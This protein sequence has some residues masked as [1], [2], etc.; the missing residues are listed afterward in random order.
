[1]GLDTSKFDEKAGTA[2]DKAKTLKETLEDIPNPQL[3]MDTTDFD[4]GVSNATASTSTLKETLI[5]ALSAIE[6][7]AKK[8][9]DAVLKIANVGFGYNMDIEQYEA[10]FTTLMGNDREGA[11]GLVRNRRTLWKQSG[12]L[13][14]MRSAR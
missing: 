1:M 11:Q 4:T 5:N 2:S 7:A 13:R 12:R 3:G 9:F 10:A 8:A 14:R 6:G